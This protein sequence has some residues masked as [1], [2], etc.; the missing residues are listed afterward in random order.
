MGW[1]TTKKWGSVIAKELP[2]LKD[3]KISPPLRV[4]NGWLIVQRLGS[5]QANITAKVRREQAHRA[6]ATRKAE[7][8]YR[9]FLRDLRTQAYIRILDSSL[10]APAKAS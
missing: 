4:P 6:I 10:K 2:Q 3:G 7:E 8:S 5:R 9:N 1:F